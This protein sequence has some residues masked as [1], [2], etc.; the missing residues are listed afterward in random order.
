MVAV[1]GGSVKT[2]EMHSS[3][4]AAI[5]PGR[6]H[7]W[8]LNRSVRTKGT[9]VVAVPLIALIGVTS[10]SLA[11]QYNERQVR[12]AAMAASAVSSSAQQVMNDALNAETGLRGYAAT[13]DPLF[14]QPYNLTLTHIAKDRATL[15]QATLAEGTSVSG[16]A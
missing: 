12:H 2:D 16:L 1:L 5:R 15:R 8:W 4:P 13:G 10:A 7:Q 6:L 11:L 3:P 14:L 9:I